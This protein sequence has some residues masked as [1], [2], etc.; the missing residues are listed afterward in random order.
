MADSKLVPS[1]K[2]ASRELRSNFVEN[3]CNQMYEASMTSKNKKVPWGFV[4]K[5]LKDAKKE[6]PWVTKNM[7]NFAY[8]KF[9][10]KKN[11]G[12]EELDSSRS[13]T[14][15]NKST[16]ATT[17]TNSGGR[18]KGT[19]I[20]NQH[21]HKEALR[22]AK[23][24]IAT[25]Y[26]EEKTKCNNNG[27]KLPKGWLKMTIDNVVNTRGLP[28]ST[29]ISLNTIRNQKQAIVL[30]D[31]G[32]ATL[33]SGVEPQLV[34]L[35]LAM[36]QARRCLRASECL[37]LANDLIKG[38]EV[39]KKII[40]RKKKRSERYDDNSPVLGK[41]YWQLFNKRWKHKLV[42]RRGQKFALER[43]N[44]LTYHNVKKMYDDV[45][46]ALVESGNAIQT[47]EHSSKFDGPLM[48]QFHLTHPHN[49]LVVDEVG[50]DT[51]QKGD[52][53][54]GGAKYYCGRGCVP[55]NQSSSNDKHF[56]MLGFTALSGQP[57]MCLVI[58]AG[59]QEKW[60]VE[61]GIDTDAVPV[62]DPGD[63]NFFVNNRG[64]GKMFPLGPDCTFKGK[65]VPTM[66]RW[67][68]SGSITSIILRDALATMDHHDLFERS[69]NRMPFLLLDGHHSRFELPFLEYVTNADHPW[70]ICIGVPYGTSLWQVADSKEQNGSYKIAIAKAKKQLLEKR[71]D[72]YLD[73][74]GIYATDIMIIVNNAW[75]QSFARIDLNKKAISDRGWGPLNYNLLNDED[76]KATM[77]DL[78]NREFLSMMKLR[79]MSKTRFE[80]SMSTS[81]ISDLTD[82]NEV[83][84]KNIQP[85][86]DPRYLTKV[87]SDSVTISTKLNFSA[88]RAAEVARRLIHDNDIREAREANKKLAEK[89]KLAKKKLEE[90]K[91][92]TAMLN[93]NT[94]GCKVGEDSLKIRMELAKKKKESDEKVQMKKDKIVNERKRKYD[95]IQSEIRDKNLPLAQ[96][97]IVQLKQLCLHKKRKDDKVSISKLK[98]D[99]LL[100][101]WML[102]KDRC[103]EDDMKQL[104]KTNPPIVSHT[105]VL[106]TSI[107]TEDVVIAAV[108]CD[109]ETEKRDEVSRNVKC[110]DTNIVY[111]ST[112]II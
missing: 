69:S 2:N 111:D 38:T 15:I 44:S 110:S 63:P 85:N 98:R 79:S 68:Q 7:I 43:S 88:G 10:L 14:T 53:H 17:G 61:T 80:P 16:T 35:I 19:T 104:S 40:E 39:E 12:N 97:S 18:P 100:Q 50:T 83:C 106:G 65:K 109:D 67:S 30:S 28:P 55:Q 94:I 57:V 20:V 108:T 96:L 31:R 41:K 22:A 36:A 66:V 42:T 74:P 11:L 64:K 25:L 72:M 3:I 23:N 84:R 5:L 48:T 46:N 89:G 95:Q 81:R 102:W 77:T 13:N 112:L 86:Y 99:E 9:R 58:I 34:T 45:Y 78:E 70:M 60:E 26:K 73:S 82:D 6:E 91:K 105:S 24:E 107:G 32:C 76:I 90:A 47:Q 56:T 8:K 4:T 54:I 87:I 29:S 27:K 59:V 1:M 49:C 51:S 33:M 21:H 92:L 93:F 62:G 37:S 52:G 71:L 75:E 103:D 101:L